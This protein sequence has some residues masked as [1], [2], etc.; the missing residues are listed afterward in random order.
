MV[1]TGNDRNQE[2]NEIIRAPI[3]QYN[4]N[5]LQP[6][7]RAMDTPPISENVNIRPPVTIHFKQEVETCIAEDEVYYPTIPQICTIVNA[8]TD[9]DII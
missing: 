6:P 1:T 5:F 8:N 9:R 4:S 7:I 3:D 2:L